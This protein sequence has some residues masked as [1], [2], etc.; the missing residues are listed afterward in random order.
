MLSRLVLPCL[1]LPRLVLSCLVLS[2]LVL[3]CLVLCDTKGEG[4]VGGGGGAKDDLPFAAL[5]RATLFG[6]YVPV[7]VELVSNAWGY[8]S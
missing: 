2:C 5:P 3:S 7:P 4:G 8:E 1:S 6:A